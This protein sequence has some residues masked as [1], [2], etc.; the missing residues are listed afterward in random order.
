MAISGA[1]LLQIWRSLQVWLWKDRRPHNQLPMM[2]DERMEFGEDD[3]ELIPEN[4]R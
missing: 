3:I 1:R 4:L 2:G